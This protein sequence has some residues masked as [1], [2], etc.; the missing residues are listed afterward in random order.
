MTDNDKQ[1]A[2]QP[3]GFWKIRHAVMGLGALLLVIVVV[4]SCGGETEDEKLE[5]DAGEAIPRTSVAVKIPTPQWQGQY[6]SAQ[7]QAR[8][9]LSHPQQQQPYGYP[10][11]QQQPAYGYPSQQQPGYAY[12]SEQQPHGYPS[13]QQQP[14]GSY[15]YPAQ[16]P[17]Q[18]QLPATDPGNPWAVQRPVYGQGAP[19]TQQWGQ[20]RRQPPV[21][22]QPPGSGQ[23]RPLDEKPRAAQRRSAAPP[24]TTTGW[25]SA[26]YDRPAGS[27]FGSN[28]GS[29]YPHAGEYPGYYGAAPYGAPAY[30]GGWPG[31][32]GL[33]YP[34]AGWPAY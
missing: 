14:P 9:A 26:P 15:G 30:G 10:A 22:S 5:A 8:Q 12:P 4:R 24:A 29:A 7:Q 31:G 6:P 33:G 23:Y 1:A 28:A 13:Q 27:S 3:A 25:Q 32:A 11:Q 19:Q 34:G 17:Q 21:Y 16:Q 18:P 2:T 20:S